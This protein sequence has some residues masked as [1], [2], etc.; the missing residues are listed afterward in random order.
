MKQTKQ[1]QI[2]DAE[3]FDRVINKNV[4]GCS[5]A[6]AFKFLAQKKLE[7]LLTAR[8]FHCEGLTAR[9]IIDNFNYIVVNLDDFRAYKIYDN[10]EEHKRKREEIDVY[11]LL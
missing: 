9:K 2:T 11:T 5:R 7:K 1:N 8:G 10:F 6:E 3:L 4:L